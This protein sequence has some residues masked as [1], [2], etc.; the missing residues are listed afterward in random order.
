[1]K[2]EAFLGYYSGVIGGIRFCGDL[3]Y[4][5][6]LEETVTHSQPELGIN[7]RKL[8]KGEGGSHVKFPECRI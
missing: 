7:T 6:A 5:F 3:G 1:M 4:I 8:I 2:K